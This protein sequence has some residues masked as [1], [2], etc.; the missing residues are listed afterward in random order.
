MRNQHVFYLLIL[1]VLFMTNSCTQR[2][3]AMTAPEPGVTIVKLKDPLCTKNL[4]VWGNDDMKGFVLM[5]GNECEHTYWQ[6]FPVRDADGSLLGGTDEVNFPE[7]YRDPFWALPDG[8]YLIDWAWSTYPYV[9]Y[10]ILTDVTFEN[11]Y[12]YRSC[13]FDKSL[14]HITKPR[15]ELYETKY[16]Y[17][18]DLM[19]YIHPDGNYP[20]YELRYH[21][22]VYDKDTV[23]VANQYF[24][25]SGLECG[26][27]PIAS[28]VGTCL[29]GLA[30]QMDAYWAVLQNQLT[31]LINNGDLNKLKHFD[32]NTLY[33]EQ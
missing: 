17:V 13:Y 8:W 15:D 4:I 31:T 6:S 14:P 5:R 19:A 9:G 23:F 11:M 28:N 7:R 18:G 24:F 16:I 10:T 20:S 22:N 3:P 29:C 21:S 30:D 2:Q 25:H 27:L 33:Q 12:E 32:K 1:P 26:E